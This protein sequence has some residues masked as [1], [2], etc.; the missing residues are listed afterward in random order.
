MPTPAENPI[1]KKKGPRKKY[2]GPW[3]SKNSPK[4]Y[5]FFFGHC[6]RNR[7]LDAL[8]SSILGLGQNS[9][10]TES[11][12]YRSQWQAA[13]KEISHRPSFIY[14]TIEIYHVQPSTSMDKHRLVELSP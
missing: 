3:V 11:I 10:C 13:F 7:K 6:Q 4:K 14:P 12:I 5:I 9:L 2:G 1:K 8:Q